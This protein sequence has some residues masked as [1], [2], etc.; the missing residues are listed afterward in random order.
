MTLAPNRDFARKWFQM[1]REEKIRS[2]LNNEFSVL[3]LAH[4]INLNRPQSIQS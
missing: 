4:N 3:S 2:S 1:R